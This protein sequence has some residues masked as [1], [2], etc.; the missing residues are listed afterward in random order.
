MLALL[1][2]D[3]LEYPG[4]T[5]MKNSHESVPG[6]LGQLL[7]M[8]TLCAERSLLPLGQRRTGRAGSGPAARVRVSLGHTGVTA[9]PTIF[10]PPPASVP[11]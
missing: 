2:P 1:S 10:P 8:K 4:T 7:K 6:L 5:G 9:S 3:S 11:E